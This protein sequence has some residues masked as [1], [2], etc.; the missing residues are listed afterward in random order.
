M[1]AD[2]PRAGDRPQMQVEEPWIAREF[3]NCSN[4]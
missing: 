3:A 4:R 1:P 2:A